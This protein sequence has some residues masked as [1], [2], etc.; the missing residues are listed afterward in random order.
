MIIAE[1]D[2]LV[3]LYKAFNARDIEAAL[4]GMHDDIEWSNGWEG[5]RVVGRHAVRDYWTRQWKAIDPQVDP[6]SFESNKPGQIVVR[7]RQLVHNR[8]GILIFVGLAD[9]VYEME[10]GLIRRMQIL[11]LEG[12]HLY[13]NHHEF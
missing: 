6:V 3:S 13:G 12:T 9:H 10:D 8:D 5:G 2:L 1:H 4:A 7:V 11:Q